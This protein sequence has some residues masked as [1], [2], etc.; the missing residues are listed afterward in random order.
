MLSESRAETPNNLT[1]MAAIKKS[2]QPL[3][4]KTRPFPIYAAL[5]FALC[6]IN[7]DLGKT[8]K[9]TAAV[10]NNTN[11]TILFLGGGSKI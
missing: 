9:N 10:L 5:Q 8:K 2:S 4:V 7:T 3:D 6:D 11:L 1:I